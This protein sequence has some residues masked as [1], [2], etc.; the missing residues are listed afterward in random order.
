[1][2][3]LSRAAW[4]YMAI[5]V[6]AAAAMF[7]YLVVF[8]RNWD[9]TPRLAQILLVLAILYLI[10]DSTPATL[11]SR[12]SAWSPSSSAALAAVVLLGP[13][14]ATGFTETVT[15]QPGTY[16][17]SWPSTAKRKAQEPLGRW[18][19]V[20]SA[21]DTGG[22]TS[23]VERSFWLNDT[24]GFMTVAP[25]SMRLGCRVRRRQGLQRQVRR[26]TTWADL[27]ARPARCG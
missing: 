10:C 14:G 1:M 24:L 25:R 17:Y 3:K 4:L 11:T 6:V 23:S 12:Q 26:G 15:R 22:Q 2:Q 8:H 9:I 20:V 13:G 5:V 19:W 21:T 7:G 16:T 18:R 27:G